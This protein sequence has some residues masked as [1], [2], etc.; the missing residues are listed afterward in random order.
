MLTSNFTFL[1]NDRKTKIHAVKWVGESVS[2]VLQIAY[3][4]KLTSLIGRI[5]GKRYRSKMIKK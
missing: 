3:A 2:A 5:R 4:L 1:S